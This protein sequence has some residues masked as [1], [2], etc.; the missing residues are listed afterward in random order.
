MRE[1]EFVTEIVTMV[2]KFSR[3]KIAPMTEVEYA[4]EVVRHL[5]AKFSEDAIRA[6]V[7]AI[8]VDSPA[9]AASLG[10]KAIADQIYAD[11]REQEGKPTWREPYQQRAR[12]DHDRQMAAA[13]KHVGAALPDMA[14]FWTRAAAFDREWA[15]GEMADVFDD[16]ARLARQERGLERPRPLADAVTIVTGAADDWEPPP[17]PDD[18]IPF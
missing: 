4:T 3:S 10:A 14:E 18:E 5:R 6:A 16:R 13:A 7:K 9:R 11:R 1:A 2:R 8:L 17:T 12:T 15:D